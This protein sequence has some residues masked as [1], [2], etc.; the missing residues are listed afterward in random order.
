[1][2]RLRFGQKSIPSLLQLSGL[3]MALSSCRPHR[4]QAA[5]MQS[6]C[7][8]NDGTYSNHSARLHAQRLGY[9]C[10]SCCASGFQCAGGQSDRKDD[11]LIVSWPHPNGWNPSF[12]DA[13][14]AFRLSI[15]RSP[16]ARLPAFQNLV[17]SRLWRPCSSSDDSTMATSCAPRSR[18]C[19][20]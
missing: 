5:P 19:S 8:S 4:A 7:L 16:M 12:R 6:C 20:A 9:L 1:M 3:P 15:F 13:S 10:T 2:I 11:P 18:Q 14:K 17:L